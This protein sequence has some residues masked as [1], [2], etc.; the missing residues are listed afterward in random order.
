[1]EIDVHGE[2]IV[3]EKRLKKKQ[4]LRKRKKRKKNKSQRRD[5]V[6]PRQK[7]RI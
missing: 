2:D 5:S 1:M 4:K 6:L 3:A 7:K